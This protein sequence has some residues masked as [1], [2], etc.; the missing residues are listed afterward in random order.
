MAI[1]HKTTEATVQFFAIRALCHQLSFLTNT[2]VFKYELMI[3]AIVL[4]NFLAL[5]KLTISCI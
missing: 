2:N 4:C 3:C 1:G 5:L